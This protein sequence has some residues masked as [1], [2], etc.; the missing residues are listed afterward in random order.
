MSDDLFDGPVVLPASGQGG[1]LLGE[2]LLPSMQPLAEEGLHEERR[3]HARLGR[4]VLR[5]V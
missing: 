2:D 4:L 3:G 1:E 5:A